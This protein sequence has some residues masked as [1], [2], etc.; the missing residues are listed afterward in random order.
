MTFRDTFKTLVYTKNNLENI[1]KFDF[2]RSSLIGDAQ[3]V[4]QAIPVA[5]DTYQEA[6]E[7]LKTRNGRSRLIV[8]T[9]VKSLLNLSVCMRNS[10]RNFLDQIL[11]NTCTLK[12]LKQLIDSWGILLI[13]I[14]LPKLDKHMRIIIAH[15]LRICRIFNKKIK[16]FRINQL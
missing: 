3:K 11:L 6:W 12:A 13:Q 2:L 4:I 14:L 16:Y 7:L 9:H 1:Q 10:I 8:E 5:N 15:I